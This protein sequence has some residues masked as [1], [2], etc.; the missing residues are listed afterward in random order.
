MQRA[1]AAAAYAG[2]TRCYECTSGEVAWSIL[3][4]RR[5][6]QADEVLA[7]RGCVCSSRFRTLACRKDWSDGR[8]GDT[9]SFDP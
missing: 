4:D 7:P 6:M 8:R 2:Q 9:A 1:S 5:T 3:P